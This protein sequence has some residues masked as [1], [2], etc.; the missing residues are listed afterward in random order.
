MINYFLQI[1]QVSE[2]LDVSNTTT[3]RLI[4]RGILPAIRVGRQ[5]RVDSRQLEEW[6]E[7]GGKVKE[8]PISQI[9]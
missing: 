9:D 2:L 7:R 4:K 6:I 8:Q 3:R 1:S 5:I